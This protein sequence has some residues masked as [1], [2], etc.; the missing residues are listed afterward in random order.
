MGSLLRRWV[1][2]SVLRK[3]GKSTLW[4][5]VGV[6]QT[7]NWL[8][9][10]FAGPVRSTIMS[11]GIRSGEIIEIRHSGKTA[12]PLRKERAKKASMV[13]QLQAADPKQRGRRGRKSRKLHRRL[14]G[15]I[16]S[17]IAGRPSASST[18]N[19]VSSLLTAA[20]SVLGESPKPLSRRAVRRGAKMAL[21]AAKQQ[22]KAARRR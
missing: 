13:A 1:R 11:D 6:L 10:R 7:L 18:S 14:A 20:A 16:I 21:R 19:P 5:V 9:K 12:K 4:T 22:D 8:R 2:M 3:G 15:T 17:E